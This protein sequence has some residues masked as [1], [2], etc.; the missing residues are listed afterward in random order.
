MMKAKVESR[1]LIE[2]FLRKAGCNILRVPASIV[3]R[4]SLKGRGTIQK[5][6]GRLGTDK[7]SCYNNSNF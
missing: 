1:A 3:S 5:R 4:P 2:F 6:E 7:Q